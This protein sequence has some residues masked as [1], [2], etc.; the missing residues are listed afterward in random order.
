M[1]QPPTNHFHDAAQQATARAVLAEVVAPKV[2]KFKK[3]FAS[4]VLPA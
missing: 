1:P 4:R 2:E 3:T